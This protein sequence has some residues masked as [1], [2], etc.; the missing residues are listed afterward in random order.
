MRNCKIGS[1]KWVKMAV[2][3]I[4]CIYLTTETIGSVGEHFSYNQ[5]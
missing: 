5:K 2:F 3:C 4:K 1:Q